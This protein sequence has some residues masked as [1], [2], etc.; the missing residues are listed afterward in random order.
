MARVAE[1]RRGDLIEGGEGRGVINLEGRR[2]RDVRV[3][4]IFAKYELRE[5]GRTCL[6]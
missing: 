3:R 2:T 5:K 6:T 1:E 4:Y